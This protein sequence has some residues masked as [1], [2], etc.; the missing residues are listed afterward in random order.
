MIDITDYPKAEKVF[1]YFFE[2]TKIPRGSGNRTK[3]TEYL[4]RFANERNLEVIRDGNDN[5]IIKKN[6][7][8]GYEDRPTVIIQAHTDMVAEKTPDCPLDMEKDGLIV[9]R[10]GDF[11]RAKGT[12]LGGDDGIGVAFAL[13]ILDSNDIPHPNVEAIFTSDEEIGLLGASKLDT[14]NLE[15]KFLIN[16]DSD[17]E[18]IFTVGCAG[19]LRVDS[20]LPILREE[21]H[22]KSYELT[23]GGLLGGHSGVEIDKNRANA[24]KII[25]RILSAI[26]DIRLVSLDGGNADNAIPRDSKAVFI[27]SSD[28]NSSFEK[29]VKRIKENIDPTELGFTVKLSE[30]KCESIPICE[31]ATQKILSLIKQVPTGVV[32]MSSDIDGLVETSLNIGIAETD[33]EAFTLSVSLRSSK[34]DEKTKLQN[35]VTDIAEGLGAS[36]STRGRY[37]AWEFKKDS[38]LLPLLIDIY[39]KMNNKSPIINITHAGLECGIFASKID[40]VDCVSVGPTNFDIHTPNEHLSISSTSRVYEFILEILKNLQ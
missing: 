3:I 20:R 15:G 6:A 7:T 5:V 25:A 14:S 40:G 26:P 18:G 39:E 24:I 37:P 10:D 4:V 35:Q 33:N 2:I 38:K 12:S 19:G 31:D 36:V 21:Y 23:V 22:G 9:F 27:T 32:T 29:E 17:W 11:I 1:S 28:V 16:V 13:T 34:D 8:K 30:K